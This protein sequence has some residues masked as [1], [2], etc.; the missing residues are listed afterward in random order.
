MSTEPADWFDAASR[1]QLLR[2]FCEHASTRAAVQ[3]LIDRSPAEALCDPDRAAGFEAL[4]KARDRETKALT[5]L[6]TGLR[7]TPQSRYTPTAAATA[8]RLDPGAGR[9]PWEDGDEWAQFEK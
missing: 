1:R 2:L 4:L 6:A 3:A 9:R 7:L 8:G 5:S